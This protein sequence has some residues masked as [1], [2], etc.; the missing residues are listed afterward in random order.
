MRKYDK[1]FKEEAV[2]HS[3]EVGTKQAAAQLGVAYLHVLRMASEAQV[4][5][6]MLL[7]SAAFTAMRRWMRMSAS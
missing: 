5:A 3:D 7:S 4:T 1:E 2:K 6:I